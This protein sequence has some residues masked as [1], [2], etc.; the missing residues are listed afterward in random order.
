LQQ[1]VPDDYV[2]ATGETYSVQQ[3]LERTFK[4]ADLKIEDH[5]EIDKRLFRPHEVPLLLGDPSRAK[6]KLKW[7]PETS[8]NQLVEMMY[9]SDLKKSLKKT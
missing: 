3:F 7:S 4:I 8:F 6:D 1:E 9:T 2:I 5:V